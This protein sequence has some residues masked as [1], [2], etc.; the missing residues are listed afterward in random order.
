MIGAA[1]TDLH[2]LLKC[3]SYYSLCC[4]CIS[5]FTVC[6]FGFFGSNCHNNCSSNCQEVNS[7]NPV[8]GMCDKG[9]KEGW[10]GAMCDTGKC[11]I[12]TTYL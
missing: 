8:T 5:I 2:F 12:D 9:C 1:I 10:S 3:I 6:A 11:I 4:T 7:C